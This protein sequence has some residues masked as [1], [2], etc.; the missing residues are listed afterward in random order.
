MAKRPARRRRTP[1]DP[2]LD[3][4][5]ERLEGKKWGD[6]ENPNDAPTPLIQK[7]LRLRRVPLRELTTENLRMLIGQQIGLEHLVPLALDRLAA[8][9]LA[10]GDFYPGDLLKSVVRVEPAYWQTHPEQ[11][12][13]LEQVCNTAIGRL[14]QYAPMD[15]E[16]LRRITAFLDL[17]T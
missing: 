12:R 13:A 7:C 5:L 8:D 3:S 1:V 16:L 4:T 17:P 6:P 14:D 11:R 15:A 2:D 9:P 10:E